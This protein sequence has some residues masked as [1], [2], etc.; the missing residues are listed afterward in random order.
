MKTNVDE[1]KV[2]QF[3]KELTVTAI[4]SQPGLKEREAGNGKK[5][6]PAHYETHLNGKFLILYTDEY[7]TLRIGI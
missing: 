2:T 3:N 7:E 4:F 1:I 6:V 5:I